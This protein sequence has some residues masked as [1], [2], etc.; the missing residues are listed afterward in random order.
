[1]KGSFPEETGAQIGKTQILCHIDVEVYQSARDVLIGFGRVYR[2]AGLWFSM[3]L[4]L[5]RAAA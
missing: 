1:L 2:L 4:V 3:I 5:P